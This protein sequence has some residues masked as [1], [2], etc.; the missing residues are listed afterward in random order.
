MTTLNE[1]TPDTTNRLYNVRVT[2]RFTCTRIVA[3]NAPTAIE[4]ALDGFKNKDELR[5]D[6]VEVRCENI[7]E[8]SIDLSN[9]GRDNAPDD[10]DTENAIFDI[11]I[12]GTD[13]KRVNELK[14]A[15]LHLIGFPGGDDD[16]ELVCGSTKPL[17][18]ALEGTFVEGY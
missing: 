8:A 6:I 13:P 2:P 7:Y 16:D 15:L 9:D 4:R 14:L 17:E 5:K 11:T 1:L 3:P 18:R 10:L 12:R